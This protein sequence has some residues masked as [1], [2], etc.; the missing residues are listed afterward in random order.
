MRTVFQNIDALGG[1]LG[2]QTETYTNALFIISFVVLLLGLL[3]IQ[4]L[5][6]SKHGRAITAIRDSEIAA[7]AS[8]INVTF[9]KLL[10]FVVA[11]FFAGMAGSPISTLNST[12]S[13]RAS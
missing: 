7:R 10:A 11:A 5:V 6:R 1:P 3:V 12:I 2:L 9:Y 8:G 13:L 4:N